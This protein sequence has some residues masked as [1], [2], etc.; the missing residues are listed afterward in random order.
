M[1]RPMNGPVPDVVHVSADAVADVFTDNEVVAVRVADVLERVSDE[2]LRTEC[3]RRDATF[4][5]R[6]E[7]LDDHEWADIEAELRAAFVARDARHFDVLL[8]RLEAMV[9]DV[10]V[11]LRP[12]AIKPHRVRA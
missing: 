3:G 12:D 6:V 2:A 11:P 1:P 7:T 10:A 8:A 9:V 4:F 5:A